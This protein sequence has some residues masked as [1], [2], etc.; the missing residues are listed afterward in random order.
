MWSQGTP[1][2]DH[3]PFPASSTTRTHMCSVLQPNGLNAA[4]PPAAFFGAGCLDPGAVPNGLAAS[5]IGAAGLRGGAPMHGNV[6]VSI[7]YNRW[8]VLGFMERTF[9]IKPINLRYSFTLIAVNNEEKLQCR[10]QNVC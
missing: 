3:A 2:I 10:N 5:A 8:D 1:T 7:F 6:G 9:K 4:A